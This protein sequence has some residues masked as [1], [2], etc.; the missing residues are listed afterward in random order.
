[1][2]NIAKI[3]VILCAS[4]LNLAQADV[5]GFDPVTIRDE[6][7]TIQAK[8]DE[9]DNSLQASRQA[10]EHRKRLVLIRSG[11]KECIFATAAKVQT[12]KAKLLAIGDVSQGELKEVTSS[13]R[14]LEIEVKQIMNASH[15][16]Y[17]HRRQMI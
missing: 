5:A 7:A 16:H 12:L 14:E 10:V 11:A 8:L 4:S 2:Y 1:M 6:L 3:I 9:V 15:V 13:R 17:L